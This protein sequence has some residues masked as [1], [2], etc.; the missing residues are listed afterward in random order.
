MSSSFSRPSRSSCAARGRSELSRPE[1]RGG[2]LGRWAAAIAGA[3]AFAAFYYKYVPLVPGFQAF[4]APVLAAVFLFT[5]SGTARGLA[6]LVF[7]LPLI[8][9]LPYFFGITERIPHAPTALPLV[10]AFALGLAARAAFF[11]GTGE[12]RIRAPGETD[13]GRLIPLGRPITVL[14]ALV[15]VSAVVTAFRYAGFYPFAADEVLEL[16]VN[17][18]G[19][20]AGGAIM[21]VVFNGLSYLAGFLIFAAVYRAPGGRSL[22][23]R[24]LRTLTIAVIPALVFAAYQAWRAPGL[25]N[26]PLWEKLGQINGTFKDPNSLAGFLSA[27]IPVALGLALAARGW[28]KKLL[29]LTA[30]VLAL[31][32]F[33]HAGSRSSLAGLAVGLFVFGFAAAVAMRGGGTR[34]SG[35]RRFKTVAA[36]GFAMGAV[37]LA[38][39]MPG[40]FGSTLAERMAWSADLIRG[41]LALDGFFNFRLSLW[42]AALRMTAAY[43]LSGVGIGAYI[44][45]LPNVLAG[46]GRFEMHTDSALNYV[47]QAGAELG[48]PGIVLVV[49][50][51]GGLARRMVRAVR[52]RPVDYLVLGA[53]SGLAAFFVAFFFHTYI[54]SFEVIIFFWLLAGLVFRMTEGGEAGRTGDE[55]GKGEGDRMGSDEA[56]RRNRAGRRSGTVG[57]A[58]GLAGVLV[59][60][61]VHLRNSLGPLSVERRTEDFGWVQDFGFYGWESDDRGF[62]FRWSGVR[63]GID[64]P[65]VGAPLVLPVTAMHP[66]IAE[67]PV[68]IRIYRAD[69]RFRPETLLL[70]HVQR[71]KEWAEIEI[72]QGGRY[73]GAVVRTGESGPE[74]ESIEGGNAGAG[75]EARKIGGDGER[76]GRIRLF[77]EVDRTWSPM[78]ELGVPDPR[79][80]GFAMGEPWYRHPG[81][82]PGEDRVA[83][84]E[85]FAAENWEGPWGRDLWGNASARLKFWFEPEEGETKSAAFVLFLRGNPAEDIWPFAVIRLDGRVIG[86]TFVRSAEWMPVVLYPE[87]APGE[88]IL[89]VQFTNDFIN[90]RTG[91]DRNLSLGPLRLLYLIQNKQINSF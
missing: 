75:W 89:S 9:S 69:R 11:P 43:P 87:M 41:D 38:V 64:M 4:L 40:I 78:R 25:G 2:V 91:A 63:V 36:V 8:N 10:L 81:E 90:P 29:P 16:V 21:S 20:R 68:R 53:A 71:D 33:P 28:E 66:D 72:S 1:S 7:A 59:M 88:R 12:E 15:A 55:R 39:L 67:R 86:R 3:A 44:V 49:W 54:G 35:R 32:V 6:A 51:F 26:T 80:I 19:V 42:A 23:E 17:T 58:V 74:G 14:A 83:R 60:G 31:G 85:T 56:N 65:D 73:D 79:E 70:E 82:P 24:L 61:A 46:W 48:L 45:E 13:S 84:R 18:G 5:L 57:L 27:F 34:S 76:D 77:I 47:L 37:L 62:H 50:I 22:S 52:S 30:A